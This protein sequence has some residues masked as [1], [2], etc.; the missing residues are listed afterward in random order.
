MQDAQPGL[1]VFRNQRWHLVEPRADALVINIGDIV[2][3]WSNDRYRASLH[4]VVADE[5]A[6]RFS[7][8][9]F[10]NPAYDMN[11]A[12]LPSSIDA[13]HPA[14]YSA[15]NWG[16]FREQRAAGDYADY[17]EE[18]QISDYRT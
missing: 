6:E 18:V 12:P 16:E 8:P 2:Q 10:F 5:S 11:Y 14:R 3:V 4:R 9:F 13:Q 1:E 7:A 15:I 17:G